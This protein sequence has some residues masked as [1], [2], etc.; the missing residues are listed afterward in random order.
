M[1]KKRS[2]KEQIKL[3]TRDITKA[4]L[5]EEKIHFQNEENHHYWNV[6]FA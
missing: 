5:G 3:Q 1:N 6:G 2:N 4:G